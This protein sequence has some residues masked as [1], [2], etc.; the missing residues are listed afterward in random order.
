MQ[1]GEA[2]RRDEW[3]LHLAMSVIWN[4]ITE[5]HMVRAIDASV[6]M[7]GAMMGRFRVL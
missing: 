2:R 6:H 5:W 7:M 1:T 3:T 4:A